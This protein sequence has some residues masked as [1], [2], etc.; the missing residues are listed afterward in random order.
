MLEERHKRGGYRDK[1]LGRDIDVVH[2]GLVD[3]D[4]VALTP[5][6]DDVLDDVEVGVKLDVGLRD[7]V[8]I[9][10]PRG[11]IE[12]EGLE[13]HGALLVLLQLRVDLLGLGDLEVVALAVRAL[14]GVRDRDEVQHFAVLH[15]SVRRLDEAVFIDAGEARKR[16]DKAD[17]RAFRRLD[18]A[19]AAVVGGMHVA[20]FEACALTGETARSKGREAA[21]VG[22]LGER[23]GLIHELRELRG[24]EELADRGHDRLRVDEVVRH[25]RRHL[26]IHRHFFLDGAFHAD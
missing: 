22:D 21:L 19:D 20:D 4:E 13:L 7:G 23:V 8:A 25:G 14:A 26:L 11:E 16:A 9:F 5:R 6:I 1:L 15:A 2:I 24:A 12:G 17:V 10:L 18:R 3:Q